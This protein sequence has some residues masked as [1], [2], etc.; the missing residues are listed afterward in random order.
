MQEFPPKSR[1]RAY[2]GQT[3]FAATDLSFPSCRLTG[4][5]MKALAALVEGVNKEVRCGE[6]GMEP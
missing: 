1:P 5:R 3:L 2:L 6:V 4:S